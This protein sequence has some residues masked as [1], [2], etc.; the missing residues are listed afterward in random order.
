MHL[1]KVIQEK[2]FSKISGF[3]DYLFLC[4]FC[5][6]GKFIILNPT[7]KYGFFLYPTLHISR[8]KK[9][10]PLFSGFSVFFSGPILAKFGKNGANLQRTPFIKQS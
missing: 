2:L 5:H 4:A 1:K 7:Q 3:K 10:K 8:K 6:K 9:I